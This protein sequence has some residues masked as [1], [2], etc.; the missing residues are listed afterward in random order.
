MSEA[1]LT[2]KYRLL[3]TRKQHEALQAILD[4]QRTLYNAALEERIAYYRATGKS[5]TYIDQCKALTEC[6]R[7]LPEMAATPLNIQRGTL[8]R[9]DEAYKAFFRRAKARNGKAGFPRFRSKGRFNSFDFN[10]FVGIRYE[11]TRLRFKSMPSGLRVHMHR[12]IPDG[13][14]LTAKFKRDCKGWAVCLTVCV[15]TPEKRVV[16]SAIGI[17]VGLKT[18]AYQS[19]GVIIPNPRI[20]RRVEREMRRRQR[21]LARCKRGSNCRRKVKRGVTRQHAKIASTRATWL[22]QQTARIANS[23]DLIVAEDL[24]VKGMV[25]NKNLS[26]SISDASWARFFNMLSYKAERAGST[27]IKVNPKNTSQNCSGCGEKVPKSLA[28]RTHSCP[29]CGLVID[30][31]WNASLNILHSVVLDRGALNVAGCSERAPGKL[32]EV[33]R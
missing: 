10:E 8:R 11:G 23:Y 27:F 30:R 13:K 22:H 33:T 14:I 2:Y 4:S 29:H 20:A 25:K 32:I 3:P 24:N 21:A 18:F 15:D 28:V 26:R 19:D 5:R 6:R 17:D 12:S 9:L 1:V 16:Q 31:D 7:D